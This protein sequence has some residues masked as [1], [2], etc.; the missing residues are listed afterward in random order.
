MTPRELRQTADAARRALDTIEREPCA[1]NAEIDRARRVFR[2]AH[3][4]WL[5]ASIAALVGTGADELA[6]GAMA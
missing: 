1:T 4:D 6:E 2:N 5:D 3:R